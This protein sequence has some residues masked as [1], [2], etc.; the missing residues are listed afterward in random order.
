MNLVEELVTL[1]GVLDTADV[2]FALCGGLA[3][4][5]H[6]FVRATEDIDIIIREQDLQ[7][8]L[9]A[10]ESCGFSIPG[11][12][13]PLKP[14][15]DQ[16]GLIYRVS[17]V[18]SSELLPLDLMIVTPAYEEVWKSRTQM[19]FGKIDIPVISKAGMIIMKQIGGRRKDLLDLQFLNGQTDGFTPEA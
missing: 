10:V 5:A 3:M 6:G 19:S 13:I 17:K 4:A 14:G 16:A 18:R 7:A 2:E 1:A 12:E 11:G 9:T 8:A 15:T